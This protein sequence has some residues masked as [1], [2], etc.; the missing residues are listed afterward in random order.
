MKNEEGFSSRESRACQEVGAALSTVTDNLNDFMFKSD[1]SNSA[2]PQRGVGEGR[3]K[4]PGPDDRGPVD[5]AKKLRL[6]SG[7]KCNPCKQ[8]AGTCEICNSCTGYG[9][10]ERIPVSRGIN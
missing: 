10:E 4:Q 7:A 1:G 6:D 3:G 9:F 2:L 5:H 8:R